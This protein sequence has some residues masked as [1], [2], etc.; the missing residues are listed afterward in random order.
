[1]TDHIVEANKKVIDLDGLEK[2]ADEAGGKTFWT[3]SKSGL[4]QYRNVSFYIYD[5]GSQIAETNIDLPHVAA[6]MEGASPATIK[7]L[8][9]ELK[10]A[11]SAL[12]PF[13]AH[14]VIYQADT[15]PMTVIP[16][17]TEYR[18]IRRAFLARNGKGE[19]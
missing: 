12:E 2:L 17:T 9:A 6:F 18:H 1:M 13:A 19:G 15:P 10:E 11:R 5:G 4:P 14:Y 7:A 16:I 3:A 8:I